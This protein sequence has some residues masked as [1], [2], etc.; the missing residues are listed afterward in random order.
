MGSMATR[1]YF[2][3]STWDDQS[4]VLISKFQT[5]CNILAINSRESINDFQ[6]QIVGNIDIILSQFVDHQPTAGM[7]KD[8]LLPL[9]CWIEAQN[10]QKKY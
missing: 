2:D 3:M 1:T 10:A 7:N 9:S 5:I 6:R 8:K 4:A